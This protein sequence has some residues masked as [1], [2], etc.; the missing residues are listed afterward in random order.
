M[1]DVGRIVRYPPFICRVIA[2]RTVVV[3]GK[4]SV[5]PVSTTD[6]AEASGMSVR[7]VAWISVQSSWDRIPVS[8]MILFLRGCN[9]LDQ[10]V[11]RWRWF[12]VRVAGRANALQHL[13]KLPRADRRRVCRAYANLQSGWLE[14]LS[15]L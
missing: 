11:W 12:L 5:V 10:P 14:R 6:I 2:R 8:D 9:L 3:D 1:I 13:D 15:K 4:R 7:R